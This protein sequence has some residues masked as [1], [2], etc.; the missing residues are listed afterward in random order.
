[1]LNDSSL[2]PTIFYGALL[3]FML[4]S[5]AAL[6]MRMGNVQQELGG[7]QRAVADLR[8]ESQT[9]RTELREGLQATRADL[10]EELQKSM[11]DLREQLQT[12]MRSNHR[13]LMLALLNHSHADDGRPF[14]NLPP[15]FAATP[16]DD[17]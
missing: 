6:W 2:L 14:F 16:A 1:M 15:D 7:L 13:Q 17:A 11:I 10:R 12:E 9:T 3:L 5:I 8:E 4:G